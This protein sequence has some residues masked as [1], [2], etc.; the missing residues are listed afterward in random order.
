MRP[1]AG[2]WEVSSLSMTE[3]VTSGYS[4]G[5]DIGGTFTDCA[6]VAPDGAVTIGKVLTTPDDLSVGFFDSIGDAAS[7]MGLGDR[8]LLARTTRL[9][10]GTTVGINAL[11]TRS[12]AKVGLLATKGHGDAIR[13]MNNFGRVTG[14]SIEEMLDY[15]RSSA[16][17]QFIEPEMTKEITER[18]DFSGEVVVKLDEAEVAEAL[19]QLV[20]A[21]ATALAICYLWSHVNPVHELRTKEIVQARAP[22]LYVSCS[23]EVAPRIGEYP[24]TATT[25]MNVYIGPLMQKY[26]DRIVAGAKQRGYVGEVLFATSEGG[27]VDTG[28]V[29]THPISTCQSGP[30]SGVLGCAALGPAMG[31][32]NLI[33]TDMGGTSLDASVIEEGRSLLTDEAVLE[34][35][36]LHLRKV[37]VESIGAGGGSIAWFDEAARTIKVGPQSSGAVPGPACYGRGGTEPTVT[38]ADLLLGILDA[39]RGLAGGLKL[40]R[41][42]AEKALARLGARVGLDAVHTAAGIVEIVDSRMEDLLRRISLQKGHDPRDFVVWAFGGAAGMHASLY[43]RGL[44]ISRVVVPMNDLAS[45]WSAY[46]IAISDLTRTF[47]APLYLQSPFDPAPLSEAYDRLE[48]EATEYARQVAGPSARLELSRTAEIKYAMQWYSVEVD[49]PAGPVGQKTVDEMVDTFD[50]SYE[51]RYG[52]GSAYREAGVTLSNLRV[53]VRLPWSRPPLRRAEANGDGNGTTAAIAER[54][55]FWLELKK[56]LPTP[57]YEGKG[58]P[59]ETILDGP[60]VVEYPDTTVAVRP[61][62]QLSVDGFGNLVIS[63][64]K[65]GAQ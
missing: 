34:R 51:K 35:H 58:L 26:V 13:I 24:R 65:G 36:Q 9:A 16:P 3:E 20:A 22:E 52:R 42:A 55:V 7:K 64:A 43:S 41:D 33:S 29:K 39:D 62:Q 15:A 63:M 23:C 49:V 46:G 44:G 19:D 12:G 14:A 53:T 45:V 31:F 61:G 40:D 59:P 8:E 48:A 4:I 28:T 47:Q 57:V 38:D 18:L 37:D 25:L 32:H 1:A 54:P 56:F 6:V 21:G 17:E 27:L 5:V 60:A 10:H 30:V 2:P 50:R 11:V